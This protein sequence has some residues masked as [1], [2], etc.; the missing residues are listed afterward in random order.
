MP[1]VIISPFARN[2][3]DGYPSAKNYPYWRQLVSMLR[4]KHSDLY[5]IQV[6]V[7]GEEDIGCHCFLKGLPLRVLMVLIRGCRTWISV[8]NFFHHLASYVG[9]PG[10]VI[11]GV[12]DPRIFGDSMNVNLLK[13]RG[14]LRKD[15][16]GFWTIDYRNDDAYLTPEEVL[17]VLEEVIYDRR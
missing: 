9:K 7:E 17:N 13:G 3:I 10:V 11:F 15:Q 14:Y 6:G 1:E 4:Q 2:G 8:D 12:S 5:L 16:F